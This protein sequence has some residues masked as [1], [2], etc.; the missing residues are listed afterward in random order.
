[1]LGQGHRPIYCST[2]DSYDCGVNGPL[3]L[4]PVLEPLLLKY[5]VD[6]ALFGHLHNFERSSFP[7]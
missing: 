2:D 7:P 1:L 3:K 5:R 6:L 4:G